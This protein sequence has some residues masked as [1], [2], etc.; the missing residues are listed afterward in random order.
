MVV[1][2]ARRGLALGSDD[3]LATQ[4]AIFRRAD[5]AVWRRGLAEHGEG[6]T[7]DELSTLTTKSLRA[8]GISPGVV[9]TTH[10]PAAT[11]EA[12]GELRATLRRDEA[13]GEDWDILN[14]LAEA[15]VGTGDYGHFAPVG[16]YDSVRARVLVLDPDREFYEP[17]WVPDTVALAGMATPDA[18]TGQPRGYLYVAVDP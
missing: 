2:S 11:A 9:K 3:P 13:S 16:A 14:F 6:V 17:Y 8:F 4:D 1:N 15:Y 12:L 18:V 5:S 10:V 7:L